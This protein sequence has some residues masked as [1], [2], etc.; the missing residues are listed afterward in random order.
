MCAASDSCPACTPG[1]FSAAGASSCSTC[2]FGTM[3]VANQAD[4][5][6]ICPYGKYADANS[7]TLDLML[8]I[9]SSCKTCGNGK[10][11]VDGSA[12]LPGLDG[13]SEPFPYDAP[14]VMPPGTDATLHQS[15]DLCLGCAQNFYAQG[16]NF[17]CAACP[18]GSGT[19]GDT[20]ASSCSSCAFGQDAANGC[21]AC[22]VGQFSNGDSNGNCAACPPGKYEDYSGYPQPYLGDAEN[23]RGSSECDGCPNGK[24]NPAG[25]QSRIN[26]DVCIS[27]P[28]GKHT[29]ENTGL[30]E[31]DDC[32]AGKWSDVGAT[33]CTPC[34]VGKF[35]NPGTPVDSCIPCGFGTYT[36]ELGQAAC[37]VCEAGKAQDEVGQVSCSSCGDNFFSDVGQKDCDACPLGKS[38]ISGSPHCYFLEEDFHTCPT[39]TVPGVDNKCNYLYAGH[40]EEFDEGD[41]NPFGDKCGNFTIGE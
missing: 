5:C 21:A 31:C 12:G 14:D 36:N 27:C 25:T 6:T 20:G 15:S 8:G 38:S 16:T 11:L 22:I 41:A 7:R 39:S 30:I 34:G 23:M 1:K 2:P 40:W 37:E 33:A 28:A 18:V 17:A 26:V 29:G 13:T 19:S 3:S 24:Y 32:S 9:L 35:S 4:A 10:Y